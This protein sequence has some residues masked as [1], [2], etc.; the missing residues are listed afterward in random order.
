MIRRTLGGIIV[1]AFPCVLCSTVLA[2]HR[3]DVTA[4]HQ[5]LHDPSVRDGMGYGIACGVSGM[6]G[7]R[8]VRLPL[9]LTLVSFSPTKRR[10]GDKISV[11]VMIKNIGKEPIAIPWSVIGSKTVELCRTEQRLQITFT[12]P[13]ES[14]RFPHLIAAAML[15]G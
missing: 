9:E 13:S 15:Y 1:L 2:Q 5:R 10:Q 7:Y 6:S 11:E 8:P 4:E 3:I 12:T 14:S